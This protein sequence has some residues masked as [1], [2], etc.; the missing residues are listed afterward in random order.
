MEATTGLLQTPSSNGASKEKLAVRC[1]G[2]RPSWFDLEEARQAFAGVHLEC[3]PSSRRGRLRRREA[4]TDLGAPNVIHIMPSELSELPFLRTS[5]PAA[6]LVLDLSAE[7]ATNIGWRD[8]KRAGGADFILAG[9]VRELRELR[10]RYPNFAR[11]T[12]LFRRPI[13]L[14]AFA[15][16]GLLPHTKAAHVD[17][18]LSGHGSMSQLVLFAGPLTY[19]GG[20]DLAIK[21]VAEIQRRSPGVRLAAVPEGP[22][23]GRYLERCRRDATRVSSASL[24][25]TSKD[26]DELSLWYAAA[27]VVCLPCREAVGARP[28]KRAAAAGKPFVGSEVEPL[29]ELV[30]DGETG[31]LLPANFETLVAALEALLGDV[32]EA[33]RLGHA[34]R[35]KAKRE[36]SPAEAAKKLL[37]LWT[38]SS[39]PR[40]AAL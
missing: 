16:R 15:P 27:D 14:A 34:A 29:L 32:E 28:A 6:T 31:Y 17:R 18:L 30:D 38:E 8:A 39:A 23:D 22:V 36:L 9:S 7:G 12:S 26:V 5:F 10:R 37:G 11:R 35:L 40:L 2:A 3:P 20:L 21:A 19:E 24:L 33:G 25:L 13:D 4:N 1:L